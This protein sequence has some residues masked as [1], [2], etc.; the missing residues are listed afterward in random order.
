[1]KEQTRHRA[2]ERARSLKTDAEVAPGREGPR[3]TSLREHPRTKRGTTR[4]KSGAAVAWVREGAENTWMCFPQAPMDR[5]YGRSRADPGERGDAPRRSSRARF[6]A[7]R[8][9]ARARELFVF[10]DFDRFDTRFRM[11]TSS[12]ASCFPPLDLLLAFRKAAPS[13]PPVARFVA[14]FPAF[15]MNFLVRSLYRRADS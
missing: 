3:N 2:Q 15:F 9:Q 7:A 1:V 11:I 10:A 14:D 13:T 5:S 6:S 8:L 4:L 12:R